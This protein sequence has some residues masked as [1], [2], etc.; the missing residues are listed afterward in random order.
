MSQVNLLPPEIK[1]RQRARRVTAVVALA[2]VG[3]A[4]VVG[5]LYVVQVLN[6]SRVTADLRAQEELN[7]QLESEIADLQRFADLQE[8]LRARRELLDTVFA[9]EVSFSEALLDLSRIIP[10][11]A[12]LTDLTAQITAPT[13]AP[14][15]GA[16]EPTPLVGSMSFTGFV[17]DIDTL[18]TWLTRLEQV[19]GWVNPWA[20]NAQE[21]AALSG[22]YHFSSGVDLS[23]EALTR[24]GGRL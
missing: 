16:E 8:E 23:R 15:E 9:N 13:V 3:V 14:A 24:R 20:S 11:N 19:R 6:L 21:T 5:F 2:G 18:A 17:A 7:R 12:Y 22:Q 1:E 4:A 10:S